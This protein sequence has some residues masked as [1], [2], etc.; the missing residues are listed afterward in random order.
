MYG[1]AAI[2]TTVEVLTKRQEVIIMIH[3]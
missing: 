2:E 1:L 3:Q